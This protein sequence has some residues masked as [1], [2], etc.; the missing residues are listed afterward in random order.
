MHF[1]SRTKTIDV[2]VD[3]NDYFYILFFQTAAA[4]IAAAKKLNPKLMTRIK[5]KCH[6]KN[7]QILWS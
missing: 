6:R 1:N 4:A 7:H 3:F 2:Y 5:E